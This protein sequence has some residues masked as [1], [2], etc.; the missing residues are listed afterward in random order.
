MIPILYDKDGANVIGRLADA[1][2]CVAEEERNGP[3][4]LTL[5]YPAGGVHYNQIDADSLIMALPSEDAEPQLF[6]VSEI[7]KTVN[8]VTTYKANHISYDLLKMCVNTGN[9]PVQQTGAEAALND[10]HNRIIPRADIDRFTF[11]TDIQSQAK[12]SVKNMPPGSVR[13]FLGGREGSILDT[14]GGE[15]EWNNYEVILHKSRG[16]DAGVV[17][18]YGKNLT[19]ISQEQ[20]ASGAYSQVFPFYYKEDANI[21]ITTGAVTWNAGNMLYLADQDDP[22]LDVPGG[23]IKG[24]ALLDLTEYFEEPPTS[25]AQLRN[26]ALEQIGKISGVERSETTAEF[27]PLWQTLE[28]ADLPV[29]KVH[30][31]DI[32]HIRYAGMRIDVTA[33]VTKTE[34]NVLSEKYNRIEV[35]TSSGLYDTIQGMIDSSISETGK[36]NNFYN[37]TSSSASISSATKNHDFITIEAPQDGHVFLSGFVNTANN[38]TGSRHAEIT[39]AGEVVGD[40]TVLAASGAQTRVNVSAIAQVSQGDEIILRGWQNSGGART[41]TGTLQAYFM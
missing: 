28:Y 5:E 38:A 30:L 6:R 16:E 26:M 41:M 23:E 4:F 35:G 37:R 27:V 40:A 33:K 36:I 10:I 14:F 21:Q 20:D 25:F 32:V 13:E 2:S 18:A 11:R 31:C 3:Y 24:C 9:I 34:F 12:W 1:L 39:V 15:Y 7:S 29:Q 22:V 8:G 17:I 19:D